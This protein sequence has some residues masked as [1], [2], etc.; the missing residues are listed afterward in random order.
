M[1]VQ[2]ACER[3]PAT[4]KRQRCRSVRVHATRIASTTCKLCRSPR[5]YGCVCRQR[6]LA[7]RM[8]QQT[9]LLGL[10]ITP[11]RSCERSP[12]AG[13]GMARKNLG[14]SRRSMG[15]CA[16]AGCATVAVG[17]EHQLSCAAHILRHLTHAPFQHRDMGYAAQT[18]ISKQVGG[19]APFVAD[20]TD[21]TR[22][23]GS[24]MD[25]SA[26][27]RPADCTLAFGCPTIAS[28]NYKLFRSRS[29]ALPM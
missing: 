10:N 2:D 17:L 27:P 20:G 24:K 8:Q 16:Q 18:Y 14:T 6:K 13:T 9:Q 21:A 29:S 3:W 4:D 12:T 11:R 26:L 7:T 1:I 28:D 23:K 19:G 15:A 25:A 5:W 22:S